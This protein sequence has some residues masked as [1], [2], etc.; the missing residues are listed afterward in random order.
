MRS[1][2][3]VKRMSF[4]EDIG[5][6]HVLKDLIRFYKNVLM[7]TSIIIRLRIFFSIFGSNILSPLVLFVIR[8]IATT[9]IVWSSNR[10]VFLSV[11]S[12]ASQAIVFHLNQTVSLHMFRCKSAWNFAAMFKIYLDFE[13]NFFNYAYAQ[14]KR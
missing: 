2:E 7:T 12:V 8:I 6:H 5:N 10:Y 9:E 4:W 13:I 3:Y 14:F 11:V 1:T